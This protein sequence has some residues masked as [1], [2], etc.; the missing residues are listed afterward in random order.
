MARRALSRMLIGLIGCALMVLSA[1]SILPLARAQAAKAKMNGGDYTYRSTGRCAGGDCMVKGSGG[2]V[3]TCSGYATA[4][5]HRNEG[6]PMCE[7]SRAQCM[8][9]GTF[10]GPKGGVFSG[11]ARE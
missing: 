3:K 11:L 9:T 1:P 10:R 7:T 6:S 8:Q 4:C 5:S 2:P